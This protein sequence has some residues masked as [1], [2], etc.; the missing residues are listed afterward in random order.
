[1]QKNCNPKN[2]QKEFLKAFQKEFQKEFRKEFQE[3]FQKIPE[4]F[5][6]EKIDRNLFTKKIIFAL[7]ILNSRL[8][9]EILFELVFIYNCIYFLIIQNKHTDVFLFFVRSV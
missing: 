1:M 7:P 3:E 9:F 8:E 4:K 6:T 2:S 5:Q